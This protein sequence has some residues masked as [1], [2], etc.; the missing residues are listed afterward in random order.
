MPQARTV[1]D[2]LAASRREVAGPFTVAASASE[3]HDAVFLQARELEML[4]SVRQADEGMLFAGV[5]EAAVVAHLPDMAPSRHFEFPPTAGGTG[6]AGTEEGGTGAGGT[7]ASSA[8][9]GSNDTG[10]TG[11]GGT[12]AIAAAALRFESLAAGWPMRGSPLPF[13]VATSAEAIQGA[14]LPDILPLHAALLTLSPDGARVSETILISLAPATAVPAS[15]DSHATVTA[16]T[17]AHEE[18]AADSLAPATAEHNHEAPFTA[19]GASPPSDPLLS[20]LVSHRL[21]LH[22][23]FNSDPT[24][25]KRAAQLSHIQAQLLLFVRRAHAA[26]LIAEVSEAAGRFRR[27]A[28][29][30]FSFEVRSVPMT[31]LKPPLALS[32]PRAHSE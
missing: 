25:P 26:D 16:A 24:W 17:A 10:I 32:Q 6:A 21:S 22:I 23:D 31:W 20:H 14:G 15:A 11:T 5:G 9:E 12:G 19:D 4:F 8:S 27:G 3:L 1:S 30:V 2:I 18:T 29:I 28:T 7:E 13:L